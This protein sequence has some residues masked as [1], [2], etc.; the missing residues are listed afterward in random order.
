MHSRSRAKGKGEK[1]ASERVPCVSV[2]LLVKE[3][4]VEEVVAAVA[5]AAKLRCE[6]ASHPAPYEEFEQV[7]YRRKLERSLP[8]INQRKR[9]TGL[10]PGTKA[11]GF[12]ATPAS[13]RPVLVV[14]MKC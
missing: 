8:Q 11:R 7:P 9:W 3:E 14:G 10:Y 1:A 2:V 12:L 4:K 13:E 6:P 5:A